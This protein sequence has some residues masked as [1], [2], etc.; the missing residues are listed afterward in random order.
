MG[1]EETSDPLLS[2][3]EQSGGERDDSTHHHHHDER[4]SSQVSFH[5]L[6]ENPPTTM[7]QQDP[8][9]AHI[10]RSVVR[11]ESFV[12]Q[13]MKTSGPPQITFLMMLV[14][15]GLGSTIGVVPAVMT[16]RFA[17]L[18]HDY[19]GPDCS[20][21]ETLFKPTACFQGSADAQTAA[22]TS[23]LISNVLTFVT[24]SLIGSLSD[25][26]GRRGMF[27]PILMVTWMWENFLSIDLI[28]QRIQVSSSSACVSQHCPL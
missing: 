10:R 1:A 12:V 24:S 3:M 20:T 13:Y 8:M 4:H 21:Y 22:A 25:E 19:D 15:I 27:W 18:Q 2:S 5:N 17:R 16:D 11:R 14:A 23:N 28:A 9:N 6:P 7:Q 26:Y